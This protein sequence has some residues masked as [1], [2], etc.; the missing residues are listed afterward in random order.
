MSIWEPQITVKVLWIA[1]LTNSTVD[2]MTLLK[3][4]EEWA[5]SIKAAKIVVHGAQGVDLSAAAKVL[6]MERRAFF[7]KEYGG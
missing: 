5:K 4:F 1:K 3:Y 7:E 6:N 2:G